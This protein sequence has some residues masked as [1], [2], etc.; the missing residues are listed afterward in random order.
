MRYVQPVKCSIEVNC[1]S[2]L[3]QLVMNNEISGLM[4]SMHMCLYMDHTV[5]RPIR[6]PCGV[7]LLT[8]TSVDRNGFDLPHALLLGGHAVIRHCSASHVLNKMKPWM[9]MKFEDDV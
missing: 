8:R 4:N 6:H 7:P 2:N 5:K 1:L 9:K 3:T